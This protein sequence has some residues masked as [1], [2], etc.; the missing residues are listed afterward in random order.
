MF[1]L[2]VIPQRKRK[3]EKQ[4]AAVAAKYQKITKC[5]LI[6]VVPRMQEGNN[7]E[8]KQYDQ[9]QIENSNMMEEEEEDDDDSD[10]DIEENNR[11]LELLRYDL[12]TLREEILK[13]NPLLH[14]NQ[15]VEK[16]FFNTQFLSRFS[17]SKAVA[18]RN[19]FK[20]ESRNYFMMIV[21]LQ[22]SKIQFP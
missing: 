19:L 5:F 3:N 15:Q 20:C 17:K 1:E 4:L 22:H 13:K 8:E 16:H 12:E 7:D 2:C 18:G 21:L 14:E 9:Q 11:H 6:P 10:E